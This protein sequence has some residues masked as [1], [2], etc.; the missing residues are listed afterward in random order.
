MYN[1]PQTPPPLDD[2]RKQLIYANIV[3]KDLRDNPEKKN[4]DEKEVFETEMLKKF[5]E[6]FKIYAPDAF[7]MMTPY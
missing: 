1:V 6:R 2:L 7:V 4:Q 5:F 3:L